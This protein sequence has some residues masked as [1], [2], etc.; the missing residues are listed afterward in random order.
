MRGAAVGWDAASGAVSVGFVG[1]SLAAV[2]ALEVTE[3][4]RDSQP[5]WTLERVKGAEL[6]WGPDATG[7][8]APAWMVDAVRQFGL[9][10]AR[11]V[12]DLTAGLGGAARA[13]AGTYDTWVTGLE[14]SPVL[15]AMAMLRSKAAGLSKKAPVTSYDPEH[16]AQAGLFDLIY[17]DRL[18]HRVRDKGFFLDKMGDCVKEKGG[19][20]MFDYVIDGA[21]QSW[22]AWNRWRG[23][24][25][26]DVSPWSAQR[27]ADEL[28]QRNFDVRVTEDM[29]ELHRRQIL[30]RVERLS[31]ALNTVDPESGLLSAIARELALWWARLKV[32]GHGLNFFRFVAYRA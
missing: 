25:S 24:E 31:E 23:V 17:G 22:D 6:L 9:G 19:V 13:I 27:F 10:P 16:F 15:A 4:D 14:P 12:L 11:S 1:R 26:S 32:L 7:P 8:S 20:L 21:P 3:L 29:T 2:R 5:V 30:D 18:L 28:V